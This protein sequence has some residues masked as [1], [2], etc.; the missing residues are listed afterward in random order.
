MNGVNRGAQKFTCEGT[1]RDWLILFKRIVTG[2][3]QSNKSIKS[4]NSMTRSIGEPGLP[5]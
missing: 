1:E 5:P 3:I 2:M 4:R